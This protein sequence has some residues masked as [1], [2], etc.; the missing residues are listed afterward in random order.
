MADLIFKSAILP[1]SLAAAAVI[2][3]CVPGSVGY[4]KAQSMPTVNAVPPIP[5]RSTGGDAAAQRKEQRRQADLVKALLDEIEALRPNHR[6]FIADNDKAQKDAM[7]ALDEFRER[8]SQAITADIIAM[9]NDQSNNYAR[10][11]M[12]S[13]ER[14][15]DYTAQSI[16]SVDLEKFRNSNGRDDL[17]IVQ[18]FLM[19][20]RVEQMHQ[21]ARLYPENERIGPA[22][23]VARSAMQELGSLESVKQ[24]RAEAQAAR[25][26]AMRLRPAV[27]SNP[28]L[29][30]DFA[31]A[32]KSSIW[33]QD[34]FA[35][36]QVLK[37]NL[38]SSGWTVRRNP[39]TGI[40]L[41]RDQQA[42]LA[43]RRTDGTCFSY[44]ISVEQKSNGGGFGGTYMAS[45]NDSEMLCENVS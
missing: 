31:N 42:A 5:H 11:A 4:A 36:A 39:I 17:A 22:R 44:V 40:I 45:G 20:Y 27:R 37:V 25:V 34:E 3:V 33:T 35:Q 1:L 6:A 21:L 19:V 32:W 16:S 26:A 38:L 29:E 14:H 9:A 13:A 2:S 30:R 8:M 10:R 23:E 28:A 15:A 18:Y 12:S 41:S 43:V 7:L 24:G